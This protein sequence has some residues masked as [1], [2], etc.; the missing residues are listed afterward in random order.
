VLTIFLPPTADSGL[1]AYKLDFEHS[2]VS[3]SKWESIHKK[4]FF[5]PKPM[6]EEETKSYIR[7]MLLTDNPPEDWLDR[8]NQTQVSTITTYINDRQTATWFREDPNQPPSR[9][10]VTNELIYYW[11]IQF[12]ISPD[13]ENW[14]L[15][16]LLTLIKI[17]GIKQTKPKKMSARE[18]AEQYRQLNA[19]RRAAMGTSG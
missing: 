15:N 9:E 12:N 19:E 14:H 8:L 6:D 2:L 11:M 16:R 10:I 18:Q 1:G 7:Q 13:K 4:A 17:C 3:L 5:G